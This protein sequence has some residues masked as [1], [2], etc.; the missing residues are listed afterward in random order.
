MNSTKLDEVTIWQDYMKLKAFKKRLVREY[1]CSEEFADRFGE[2]D[3]FYEEFSGSSYAGVRNRIK[4]IFTPDA[5]N[6]LGTA[7]R[8]YKAKVNNPRNKISLSLAMYNQ[9]KGVMAKAG[10]DDNDS[11]YD[12]AI[13]IL[14][15]PDV[16]SDQYVQE[17]I[18]KYRELPE[19]LEVNE[20]SARYKLEAL[21]RR[22]DHHDRMVIKHAIK[23]A[24]RE[25]WLDK[26]GSKAKSEG[27]IDLKFYENRLSEI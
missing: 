11:G 2:Q 20:S 22:V 18:L 21:V 14:T 15:S 6:K 25:G 16:K 7:F 27:A 4:K 3:A 8:A 17:A 26:G 12:S 1:F 19:Y 24:Y 23:N 10:L 9:L 5:Y 13:E